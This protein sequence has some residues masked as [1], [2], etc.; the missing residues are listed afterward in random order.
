L[1]VS[2][3]KSQLYIQPRVSDVFKF[4]RMDST[5]LYLLR[6]DVFVPRLSLTEYLLVDGLEVRMENVSTV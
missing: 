1:V 2:I 5:L 3:Y 6:N 4:R